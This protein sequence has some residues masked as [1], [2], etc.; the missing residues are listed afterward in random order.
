MAQEAHPFPLKCNL[1]QGT[2]EKLPSDRS[3][4]GGVVVQNKDAF[5]QQKY[6]RQLHLNSEKAA[7][8]T[9]IECCQWALETAFSIHRSPLFKV[10]IQPCIISQL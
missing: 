2:K 5:Q 8:E 1:S 6:K 9:V 7:S 4:G 3:Q 10:A